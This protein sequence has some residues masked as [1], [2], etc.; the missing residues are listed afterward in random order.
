MSADPAP[1]IS[2]DQRLRADLA[3]APP[4]PRPDL[5]AYIP[6]FLA[7]A[8]ALFFILWGAATLDPGPAEARVG[9]AASE[10]VGP[11]GLV[12]GSWD[13]ALLPGRVWPVQIWSAF[14]GQRFASVAALRWPSAIAAAVLVLV[15]GLQVGRRMGPRAG[16][17]A[18]LAC[19]A[20]LAFMDRS[21]AGLG[22]LDGWF[23]TFFYRLTGSS[24]FLLRPIAPEVDFLAGLGLTAALGRVID[25]RLDAK[26]GTWAALAVL[27]G[28]WPCLAILGAVSFILGRDDDDAPP[29]RRW[30]WPAALAFVAWTLS[31]WTFARTEAWFAAILRPF[32]RP[33]ALTLV[34]WAIAYSLPFGLLAPLAASRTIRAA[35]ESSGR[36][37]IWR[38]AQTAGVLA[39]VGTVVPGLGDACRLPLVCAL[40]VGAAVAIESLGLLWSHARPTTRR[41]FGGLAGVIVLP[42]TLLAVP[43]LGYMAAAV[44]YYRAVSFVLIGVFLVAAS[45]WIAGVHRN[46]GRVFL[47][48]LVVLAGGWKV[49]HASVHAPEWNYRASQGPWGRAIGQWMP[50]TATLY[51]VNPSAFDSGIAPRERFPVDLAY[52]TGRR[53]RQI[54]APA[55]LALEPGP[56][57]HFVLLAPPEFDHWPSKGPKLLKVR[58]LQDPFGN[59]RVLARTEGD[60]YP[61]RRAELGE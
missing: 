47:A 29:A 55:S 16:V 51:F 27:A 5:S 58:T 3:E 20:S 34:A 12:Y 4:I 23:A 30:L 25:R 17:L 54:A 40:S 14:S 59:P 24:R 10:Q 35:W 9:L 15:L 57:P 45:L 38:W 26:T 42:T 6:T 44:P 43:L 48:S 33:S 22:A 32:T 28:G 46:S 60:L 8:T 19:A 2:R 36:S 49:F 31:M 11:L 56:G 7:V 39:L 1:I 13:P 53:V 52:F 18:T 50:R 41:T 61:D 21:S 37:Y